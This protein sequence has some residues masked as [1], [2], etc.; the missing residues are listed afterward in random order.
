MTPITRPL[1]K[2]KGE[3]NM[4]KINMREVINDDDLKKF[5]RGFDK[6]TL[7]LKWTDR[8]VKIGNC[9][10]NTRSNS[11]IKRYNCHYYRR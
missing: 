7:N 4:N 5:L 1:K 3:N 8:V 6:I 10:I 11:L 9:Y 2:P